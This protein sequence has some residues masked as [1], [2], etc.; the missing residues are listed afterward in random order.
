[1]AENTRRYYLDVMG[2][3]CWQL[4]DEDASGLTDKQA[5]ADRGYGYGDDSAEL[6]F[7]F[8]SPDSTVNSAENYICS[9]EANALFTKML[10]AIHVAIDEVYITSL[11][12][13]SVPA[14]HR[15]SAEESRQC[16]A[17]LQQKIQLIQP[18]QLIVLGETASRCL[19]Q[20][21]LPLDGFRAM[22]ITAPFEI[23]SLPVLVSYSPQELLQQPKHKRKAWEDLQQLQQRLASNS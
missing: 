7:V 22:N 1:M 14:N 8:L 4:R 21:S 12:K 10:A 6:M 2:I 5:V 9:G 20:K 13:Y 23:E 3:Q 17:H 11:L 18:K 15:V 19:F 16:L